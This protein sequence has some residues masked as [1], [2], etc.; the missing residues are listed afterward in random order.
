VRN[1]EKACSECGI[2]SRKV[3]LG[4]ASSQEEVIA[5]D[6]LFN[7]YHEASPT[8]LPRAL[9]F[10]FPR[11]PFSYQSIGW[12]LSWP[13][14]DKDPSHKTESQS[15]NHSHSNNDRL[16]WS[17]SHSFERHTESSFPVPDFL[18]QP[19]TK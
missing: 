18:S 6:D 12:F 15:Q 13:H 9:L 3:A 2:V 4:E 14:S 10:L 11:L 5:G 16:S 7:A 1:K 8:S 17:A 19:C